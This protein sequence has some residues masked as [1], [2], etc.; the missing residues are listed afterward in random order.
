MTF[1]VVRRFLI[2]VAVLTLAS[3]T[4]SAATPLC[5]TEGNLA[6]LVALGGG[7]CT[8]GDLLF[9]N[10]ATS[11]TDNS[12]VAVT[13]YDG[14]NS[15]TP[16]DASL[17]FTFNTQNTVTVTQ[18]L[19]LQIQYEV[20]VMPAH[21]GWA[22]NEVDVD[23]E[24]GVVTGSS[25]SADLTKAY[26]AGNVFQITGNAPTGTCLPSGPGSYVFTASSIAAASDAGTFDGTGG[27]LFAKTGN[28]G[29]QLT[30]DGFASGPQYA[31]VQTIGMYDDIVLHGGSSGSGSTAGIKY[32]TNVIDEEADSVPEPATMLLI[33]SALLGLGV[34]RRRRV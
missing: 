34:V 26:C 33:G 4:P 7:G 27:Y 10:F 25:A 22:I 1:T 14:T 20:Q 2:A 21:P 12:N 15:D 16:P 19:T 3:M 29:L 18:S 23:A 11:G 24:G 32:V 30:D 17:T 31:G 6:D 13:A 8:I 9:L 28:S 5:N